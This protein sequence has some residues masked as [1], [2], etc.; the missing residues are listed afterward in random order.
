[1][2]IIYTS[3]QTVNHASFS[4]LYFYRR[5]ALPDQC[6]TN[7]VKRTEDNM[8]VSHENMQKNENATSTTVLMV[9]SQVTMD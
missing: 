4:L 7:T 6:P 2:Q 9:V 1:M 3:L 8:C 5:H